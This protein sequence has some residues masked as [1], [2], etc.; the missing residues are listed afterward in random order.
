LP[1]AREFVQRLKDAGFCVIVHSCRAPHYLKQWADKWGFIFDGYGSHPS[2]PCSSETGTKPPAD[3][4]IDDRALRFVGDWEEM[5][6]GIQD[7]R[8]QHG[9]VMAQAGENS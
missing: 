8:A 6:Q 7:I 4:Y 1:G 2:F 5:W 3:V 9:H